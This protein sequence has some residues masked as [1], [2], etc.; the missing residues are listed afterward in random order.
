MIG[1]QLADLQGRKGEAF[2]IV[3]VWRQKGLCRIGQP[4]QNAGTVWNRPVLDRWI[5]SVSS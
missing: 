4:A 3:G 2:A 1:D 5:G